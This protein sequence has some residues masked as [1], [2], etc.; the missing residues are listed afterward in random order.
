MKK[1]L[2]SFLSYLVVTALNAQSVEWAQK[3]NTPGTYATAEVAVSPVDGIAVAGYY[4]SFYHTTGLILYKTDD[5]GTI[6]WGDTIKQENP[7]YADWNPMKSSAIAFSNSGKLFFG[8]DFSDTL[9]ADGNLIPASGGPN[10]FLTKYNLSGAKEWFHTYPNAS[11]ND[12][13]TDASGNT[14]IVI[15]FSGPFTFFGQNFLPS[16]ASDLLIAKLN[17]S[18]SLVFTKQLHGNLTAT[19]FETSASGNMFVLGKLRDTMYFDAQ[20]YAWSHSPYNDYFMLKLDPAGTFIDYIQVS[21]ASIEQ[22]TRLAINN[23]EKVMITGESCWTNGCHARYKSYDPTGAAIVDSSW[24]GETCLYACDFIYQG[25]VPTDNDEVWSVQREFN[26]L[27]PGNPN[28][29]W[30]NIALSKYDYNGNVLVRDT[31]LV[32]VPS[33]EN[34]TDIAWD[35]NQALYMAGQ[36]K[37]TIDFGAESVT[38]TD[39]TADF[40]VVK[41]NTQ[42]TTGTGPLVSDARF[43]IFPNPSQNLV[44]VSYVSGSKGP[45]RLNVRNVL[46]Q[47]I[48]SDLKND[49]LRYSAK[50]DVGSY[51]EGI[52][53]FEV[54]NGSEKQIKKVIKN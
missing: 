1:T 29:D 21:T 53:F 23:D 51:P 14:F 15:S 3:Y 50:V 26:T 39:T 49:S 34:F 38:N 54:I 2:L 48:F 43:E 40:F 9:N 16:E 5:N 27:A 8:G 42:L 35:N 24:W 7:R 47:I 11:L 30:E 37:G 10:F 36:L 41:L 12:M 31:F 19:K 4:Y 44:N 28:D 22:Y 45:V 13:H 46:G 52:Y 18:D 6:T 17:A 25:S 32:S 33:S 20:N